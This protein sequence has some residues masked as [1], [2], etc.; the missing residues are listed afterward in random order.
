MVSESIR[1]PDYI[2][3]SSRLLK[4]KEKNALTYL[5]TFYVFLFAFPLLGALYDLTFSPASTFRCFLL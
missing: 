4:H 1:A 3:D 5:L 2:K